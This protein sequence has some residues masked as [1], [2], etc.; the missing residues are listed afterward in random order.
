MPEI[1]N[2]NL[3]SQGPGGGGGGD[4]RSTMALMLL[5][6]AVFVGYQ[7]FF[8]KPKPDEQNNTPTQTQPA[9]P[10]TQ[11]T[12]GPAPAVAASAHPSA[13]TPQISAAME[14]TTTVENELYRIVLTNRG[15]QVE[16]WFLKRYFDSAGKPLDLGAEPG[17]G[18]IWEAALVVHL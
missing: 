9:A 12:P 3:Q 8:A 10:A 6:L 2:P 11:S 17:R 1:Q 13:V 4:M 18:S 14:T 5:V 7:Y 15:G 16:H